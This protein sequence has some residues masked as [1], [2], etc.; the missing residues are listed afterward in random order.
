M[1][2]DGKECF[3]ARVDET[4]IGGNATIAISKG[5]K[6]SRYKL[7]FDLNLGAGSTEQWFSLLSV[8]MIN[9]ETSPRNLE[10]YGHC[11]HRRP[12]ILHN[13]NLLRIYSCLDRSVSFPQ[14]LSNN[15][16]FRT[17]KSLTCR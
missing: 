9:P 2:I 15:T 14:S 6:R 5:Y 16:L 17:F 10:G 11:M 1:S 4:F 12:T 13:K 3:Y 8:G 7:T